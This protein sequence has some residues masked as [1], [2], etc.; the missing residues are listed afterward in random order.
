MP[1][2]L[3][4]LQTSEQGLSQSAAE[5]RLAGAG[6]VAP[7]H[8]RT[9]LVLLLRQFSTPITLILIVATVLSAAVGEIVDAGIIL[10]IILVSGLLSF[11]QEASASQAMAELLK[12]VE[13]DVS[14]LRDGRACRTRAHSVVAG[15]VVLLDTGD[16]VPGDCR[17]LDAQEAQADESPLTGE[18]YPVEKGTGVL[19]AT[20]PLADRSNCLFMGTHLV[21]GSCRA[22]VVVTGGQT[23]FGRTAAS[24][25]SRVPPTSFERGITAFGLLL[26]RVMVVLVTFILI[27]NIAL[28]RPAIDSFLFSLALAVGLTPQL[29][30]A[31]V[32]ISLS[33]G[34]RTMARSSVIVKRLSAIE[35]FGAMNVLC[36]DKTGTLTTGSVVLATSL[37]G[38]GQVSDDVLRYAALNASFHTGYANPIDDAILAKKPAGDGKRLG[39][40]PY[41]FVRRRLS[42]LVEAEEGRVLITKGA[43][44][45]VLDCCA[46]VASDGERVAMQE[47][48]V[49]IETAFTRLGEQG[50]R[51]LGLATRPFE[52]VSVSGPSDEAE[53]TFR[54][55]L[56]FED[57]PKPGVGEVIAELA[58]LGISLRMITGDHRVVA[59]H[60]ANGIGLTSGTIL[61][62]EAIEAMSD[63][64]LAVAVEGVEVFAEINPKAKER[65]IWALR[66]TGHIVGY[67]G[68]GINDAPA[69]H[70]ADVGISVDTA[71]DVAKD[72]A[73]IVLLDKDLEVL[74]Q[75]VQLGR[76]TFANTLKYIFVTTSANFGN[77]A[78]MA[79]ASLLLPFLPM[80]P[81]QILLLNFLSDLPATAIS[82]D[83]VDREQVM[84]PEAWDIHSIRDFM[85]VFGITS[86]AFDFLTFGILRLVFN[87]QAEEFRSGWFLLSLMTE[88]AVMLILR[89]R[90]PFLRS[91]PGKWLL[92]TSAITAVA[93]LVTVLVPIGGLGFQRPG[94]DVLIALVGVL[95]AY[96]ATT[97]AVK[98]SFYAR[99]ARPPTGPS[100]ARSDM[101]AA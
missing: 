56:V 5:E 17:I 30:P 67:M 50:Y 22:L 11:W 10:A 78:S 25:E 4:A 44:D 39:E 38:Q 89:T 82:G 70:A 99:K 6:A 1:A 27:V 18:S 33:F 49:E 96:I 66:H 3:E 48:R 91:R 55:F 88:L 57:P 31:I 32:S 16:L 61:T 51:V 77:M 12:T 54:G 36:T 95:A 90:R 83:S 40:I 42:V 43:I 53:M 29:L 47:R 24:L 87:A 7:R 13:V 21:R 26:L 69:L 75:G 97:E 35:D 45:G 34:A 8:H 68:D 84:Q 63:S 64:D 80:L 76:Q 71:S 74:A 72:S 94:L 23:E 65:V 58:G 20:T 46:F 60:I 73:S 2:L 79:G 93:G 41:D 98:L 85:V 81:L 37:D 86:S 19:P 101:A 14:V 52:G 15:D 92:R 9:Q 59:S 62:G 100:R 28:G